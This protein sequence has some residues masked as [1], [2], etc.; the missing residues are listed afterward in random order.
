MKF[1]F[2]VYDNVLKT[3][4]YIN[5]RQSQVHT[6]EHVMELFLQDREV[7]I[8]ARC[9]KVTFSGGKYGYKWIIEQLNLPLTPEHNELICF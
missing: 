6:M 9:D 2:K 1:M 5:N 3:K 4:V 8:I 7:L